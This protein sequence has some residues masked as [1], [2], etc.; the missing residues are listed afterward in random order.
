MKQLERIALGLLVLLTLANMVIP[1][2]MTVVL[3]MVSILALI[4]GFHHLGAAFKWA[5]GIF[6]ILGILIATVSGFSLNETVTAVNSM[7]GLIALLIIMQL[8]N[9]PIKAGNY[10]DSIV[11]LMNAKLPTNRRLYVFIMLITFLLSSILSMGTVPIVYSILGPTIK[12]R[13]G[14]E[15]EHF[16]SVAI[17]RSFTLGT[18][19]APGAATIF[20]ISTITKV[21]LQRLFIPS[22]LM[23]V[24]GLVIAYLM[25]FRQPIMDQRVSTNIHQS[26]AKL[27]W[28]VSQIVIAIV[29][30]LAIAFT[31]I[32]F[33]IGETMSDVAVAGLVVV[34]CWVLLLMDKAEH[35]DQARS[36]M[37]NYFQNGLLN[38]GSLAPFFVAIGLFSDAFEHSPISTTIAHAMTPLMT[39]L[40]W[41]SLVLIPLLVVVL[42]I[43]GIHPLASV[44]LLGQI[45]MA[46]HLPFGTLALALGLNIG[47][48][49]AYTMSPFAGIVVIIANILSVNSATVS[50]RWNGKYCLILFTFSLLFII[51]YTLL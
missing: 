5:T 18:L 44:T 34:T 48:V 1:E 35:R 20:L 15:Y 27:T 43:I 29:C 19:W 30:L 7:D 33:K 2:K 37:H 3:A 50:L 42:S 16:S 24:G 51:L 39:H 12:Q 31:L 22:F 45:M 11:K 26:T 46:I 6:L 17:S 47:S 8:F 4:A 40:S 23:G 28:R 9:V 25:E 36:A 41:G 21:P 14:E 38:G 32:H 49:I 10:Q 13:V